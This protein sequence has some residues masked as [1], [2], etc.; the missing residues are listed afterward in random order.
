LFHLKKLLDS[1]EMK[2]NP[3]KLAVALGLDV[4]GKAVV[5]D[6]SKMPHVLIAGQTGSGKSVCIN[7]FLSS[8]LFRASPAEVKLVLVDP[9]R[10]EMTH[11][12]HIP[13]LLTPVVTDLKEVVSVLGWVLE[14]MERR[15][16][17]FAEAGTRNIDR[18]NET[19]GFQALPYIVLVVDELAEVMFFLRLRWKPKLPE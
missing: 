7:A 8:L 11:Y 14:E 16:K 15:Y 4:A 12:A 10:V 19:L 13:H 5:A 2:N 1:D 17:I 18:Y 9:K 3:S 6:L